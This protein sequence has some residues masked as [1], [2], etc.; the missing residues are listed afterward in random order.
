M[1]IQEAHHVMQ[2]NIS[3][4]FL[5]TILLVTITSGIVMAHPAPTVIDWIWDY[6]GGKDTYERARYLEFTW[7]VEKEGT[8]GS[9]RNHVWDRH[10]GDYVLTMKDRKTGDDLAIYFNVDTKEGVAF[11]NGEIQEGAAGTELVDKAF[12][13]FINDTYWLLA[14]L[15]LQDYGVRVVTLGHSDLEEIYP[16]DPVN[17]RVDQRSKDP[18]HSHDPKKPEFSE[19]KE[20]VAIRVFFAK[21]VGL[22]PGDQYW[23]YVTHKGRVV[24][25]K[26][27]LEDGS[28][29]AWLWSGDK[30][31]GMGLTLATRKESLDGK[32][33][34]VFPNVRFS[35][36]MDQTAFQ[37][38]SSP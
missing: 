22:T 38:A 26:Y 16:F 8:I 14:P 20:Y 23:F 13:V 27:T 10:T 4:L 15:K 5:I 35:E 37:P 18:G 1:R 6:S 9:T 36:T 3:T 12:R 31:C 2:R 25:W 19:K 7:A 30:D 24:K 21:P 34:I 29:G 33:A 32:T 28:E 11:R 17:P